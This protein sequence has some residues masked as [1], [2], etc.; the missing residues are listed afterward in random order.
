M[1]TLSIKRKPK[2]LYGKPEQQS[3]QPETEATSNDKP[4]QKPAGAARKQ[5]AAAKRNHR[6]L[7]KLSS[8]FPA[9]INLTE[10]KPLKV[11][12]L[13]DMS[14]SLKARGETFGEGQIKN[15]LARY[16]R[17]WRYQTAL[18]AGGSRYNIEGQPEGQV[19][20]EQQQ[21]AAEMLAQLKGGA[22]DK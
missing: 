20:A 8:L 21:K 5:S 17:N 16:T 18:A 12:I 22:D 9:V 11:G 7:E 13:E 3:K 15:A 1:T 14:Q 4:A 10:P 19:T 6:R 2:G